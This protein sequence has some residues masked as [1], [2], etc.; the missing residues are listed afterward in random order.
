MFIKSIPHTITLLNLFCGCLSIVSAFKGNPEAA[1][2]FIIAASFFDFFD[3]FAARMLHCKSE[4]GKQ[5]DSLADMISF[6]LAPAVIIFGLLNTSVNMPSITFRGINP[7]PYLGF[8]IAVF[9]A[10]R[11]A[12]FNIDERQTDSF[13]GLPTPA[14]AILI[15]SLP[16]I[17]WNY[18][19]S[20][21]E[22]AILIRS[23]INNFYILSLLSVIL[24]CLL[25]AELPLMSLKFK[26]YSWNENKI[27]Y[28]FLIV[29]LIS[30]F[31]LFYVAIPFIIIFYIFLSVVNNYFISKQPNY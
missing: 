4:L 21:S 17:L 1:G 26:T 2:F 20:N 12:K 28:S 18:S 3:G 13:I 30:V 9:S 16:L 19:A 22:T 24:S 11:L 10:L 8:L 25:I 27:R 31:I 14:N 7:L 23:I 5:L 29:S 6:G 15:A